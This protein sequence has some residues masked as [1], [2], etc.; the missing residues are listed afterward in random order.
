MSIDWDIEEL[1]CL[2]CGKTEAETEEIINNGEVDELLA[3]KYSI[4]FETYSK[5]VQD[6]LPF[7]PVVQTALT[8]TKFHAFVH[9]NNTVVRKEAAL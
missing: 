2:A 7:T 6:L 8:E 1:A 5:I 4:D 3:D 9:N